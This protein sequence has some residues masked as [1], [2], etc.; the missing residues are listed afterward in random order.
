MEHYIG[1]H[2]PI[3]LTSHQYNFK[4]NMHQ[5]YEADVLLSGVFVTT[6]PVGKYDMASIIDILHIL[7][8]QLMMHTT[9]KTRNTVGEN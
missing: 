7:G 2:N 5:F 3:Y 1:Y 8:L 9:D 4:F 6:P